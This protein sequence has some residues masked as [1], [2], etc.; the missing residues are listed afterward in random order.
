MS[1]TMPTEGERKSTTWCPTC[2]IKSGQW[3]GKNAICH[4]IKK[5][6]DFLAHRQIRVFP[7]WSRVGITS[8]S[9]LSCLVMILIRT[10]QSGYSLIN[11]LPPA[12]SYFC[13]SNFGRSNFGC[14]SL[15]G[16]CRQI[17]TILPSRILAPKIVAL[18]LWKRKF[19]FN[20]D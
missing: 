5:V 1:A 4:K 19:S 12:R 15:N 14:R 11:G 9:E 17:H 6:S 10:T 8:F 3:E 18:S 20:M 16:H 2:A 13:H 7:V